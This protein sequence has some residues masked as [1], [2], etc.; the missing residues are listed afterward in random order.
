MN[1]YRDRPNF[2]PW[3]PLLLVGSTLVAIVLNLFIP[4]ALEFTGAR[5]VGLALIGLALGIDLWAIRTLHESHTAILPH[6]GSS[7]L[8]THGPFGYS[9][10]PIYAA[11]MLLMLGMGCFSSNAWLLMLA[12]VDG[13]LTHFLAIRREENHLI[14]RFGY[15]FEAYCRKVRRWI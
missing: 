15:H 7:H 9:R 3:P 2:I 6:R 11:N 10:N 4:T 1:A 8:V 5:T 12:P 13:I 14:A